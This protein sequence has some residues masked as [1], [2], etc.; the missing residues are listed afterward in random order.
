MPSTRIIAMVM[1]SLREGSRD[2]CCSKHLIYK[3]DN[4]APDR[5]THTDTHN[6]PEKI[7]EREISFKDPVT[8]E[9]A[10]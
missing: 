7:T 1:M 8:R 3:S 10:E 6:K 4:Q 2:P 9:M 5:H